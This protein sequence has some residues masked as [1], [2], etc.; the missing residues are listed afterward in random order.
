M[1]YYPKT[2]QK[3]DKKKLK[4]KSIRSV[5]QLYGL[6]DEEIKDYL[7]IMPNQT[8]D[9]STISPS[10]YLQQRKT[11]LPGIDQGQGGLLE[12]KLFR[13]SLRTSTRRFGNKL[14]LV[15]AT[16]LKLLRRRINSKHFCCILIDLT[17]PV[18]RQTTKIN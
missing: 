3:R 9:I 17:R 13:T 10:N 18:Y 7:K 8:Y 4:M 12:S 2:E 15:S 5:Y 6:T 14:L 11:V 1:K 16:K